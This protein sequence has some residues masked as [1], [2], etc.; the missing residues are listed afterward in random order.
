MTAKSAKGSSL[1]VSRI[2]KAPRRT[3]YQG[4]LDPQAMLSWLPPKGMKGQMHEFDARVGGGYR[5]SLTYLEPSHS[6]RGKTSEH[7]DIAEVRFV[8]M[9][10]D[11]RIV[12]R[13]EFESKDPAYAGPM[14]LTWTLADVPGGTEITVSC[15]N[16]P[17]GIKPADHEAGIRSSLENLAAVTE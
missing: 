6:Q 10:P 2:I 1:R 5:M 4:F 8:E 14:I 7:S 15:E 16:A 12:E 9:I 3:I 17:E 11:E 13:V